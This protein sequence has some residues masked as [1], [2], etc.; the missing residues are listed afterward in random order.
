MRSWNILI[1]KSTIQ[2]GAGSGNLVTALQGS[3][4]EKR[5]PGVLVS[6]WYQ[7]LGRR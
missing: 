2:A 6:E 5:E 1:G 7:C 3:S 4:H